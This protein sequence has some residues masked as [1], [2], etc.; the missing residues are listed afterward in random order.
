MRETDTRGLHRELVERILGENGHAPAML[1]RAAFENDRQGLDRQGDGVRVL[2]GKVASD[3]TGISDD[4]YTGA[5]SS[6]LGED[7]IWELVVCAAVGQA[8]RQYDAA[9]AALDE[10]VPDEAAGETEGREG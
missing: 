10:A 7:E 4:D 8:T 1:R 2:V 3:P 6:G 5:R 9:L